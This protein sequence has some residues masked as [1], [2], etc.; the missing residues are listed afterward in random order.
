MTLGTRET[1]TGLVKISRMSGWIFAPI[2]FL[3]GFTFYGG[4]LTPLAATQMVLLSFPF[5]LFLYGTNDINDF[6][7]DKRNPRKMMLD[8]STWEKGMARLVERIS[9]VIAC[10]LLVCSLLTL[11]IW[12]LIGMIL[13]LFFAHQYSAPPL[14]L[15]EKPPLDSFSNG[16]IYYYAPILLGASY[17]ATIL[18]FSIHVYVIF[19]C[20]MGIHSFSTVM[21]YS[22]DSAAGFKTFAVAFGKRFAAFFTFL[23]FSLTLLFPGFQSLPVTVFLLV[24]MAFSIIITI[25]PAENI[26]SYFLKIMAFLF[27]IIAIMTI[28]NYTAII[29]LR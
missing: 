1:I 24:G 29:I 15:K 11:N 13:L 19:L 22:A 20:V 7:S 8:E 21:D 17:N 16:V 14:R 3:V 2:V 9:F 5:A 10:L 26:A 4:I 27:I 23:V 18:D 28:M 6:E 25:Y 12:N